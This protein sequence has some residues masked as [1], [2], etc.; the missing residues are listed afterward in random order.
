MGETNIN[1]QDLK[2]WIREY[3]AYNDIDV[4]FEDGFLLKNKSYYDFKNGLINNKNFKRP[5]KKE[6]G[7]IKDRIGEA[8]HDEYGNK[9]TIIEY[10]NSHDIL[11]QFDNGF[12]VK[13][14]YKSFL[15]GTIKNPLNKT[16]FNCGYI[17]IGKETCTS[18]I[19]MY[20]YW[21]SMLERCYSEKFKIKQPTYKD[22]IC[23]TEWHNFQNFAK[24]FNDN[25]YEI[26]NQRMELDKDILHKGNKVYSPRTCIFVP[27]RINSL[28]I[29]CDKSRGDYPLGV[30]YRKDNN[31]YVARCSVL[32]NNKK[33]ERIYLG[34]YL[35]VCEAFESYKKYK[36]N[37]IKQVAD[38]YKD[39]IPQK[40]YNAMYNWKIEITD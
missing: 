9:M 16:I 8:K 6:I 14:T 1:S 27:A 21:E 3:R 19:L 7:L 34:Q 13:S 40:L 17:G 25:Y 39:R 30:N 38:E 23:S 2:M 10:T 12:T 36:E 11:V 33:I 37:Y 29:K 35:T 4:E 28:F 26:E 24:W 20:K 22:V 5:R 15:L 18:N 32:N 31:K